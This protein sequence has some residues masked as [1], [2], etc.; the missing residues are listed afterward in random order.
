V[1]KTTETKHAIESLLLEIK[2][3]DGVNVSSIAY[4]IITSYEEYHR[5]YHTLKHIADCFEEFEEAKDLFTNPL[6]SKYVL[7]T[8]DIVYIPGYKYNEAASKLRTMLISHSLGLSDSDSTTVSCGIQA[9]DYSTDEDT[10]SV[11]MSLDLLDNEN[12]NDERLIRDIDLSILGQS[13]EKFT[14]YE[15]NIRKEFCLYDDTE[16]RE[17]RLGFLKGILCQDKI[18][19]TDHFYNKYEKSARENIRY[20]IDFLNSEN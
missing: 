14:K 2:T 20:S 5:H 18:Y 3:K 11:L 4:D 13:K 9:T 1:D 15:N 12:F 6:L 16:Y 8:H 7:A 10:Q 17:G 19:L